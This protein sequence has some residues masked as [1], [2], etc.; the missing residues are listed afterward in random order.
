MVLR[1]MKVRAKNENVVVGNKD[2]FG[3]VIKTP[4]GMLPVVYSP[5]GGVSEAGVNLPF[6]TF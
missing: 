1:R 2:K 3:K 4:F 5:P 6:F